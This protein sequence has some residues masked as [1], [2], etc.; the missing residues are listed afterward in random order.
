MSVNCCVLAGWAAAAACDGRVS[1]RRFLLALASGFLLGY[2]STIKQTSGLVTL[3]LI[4]GTS[5]LL[6]WGRRDKKG[7]ALVSGGIALGALAL[8]GCVALWLAT[9]GLLG[10]FIEQTFTVGPSSKGGLLRSLVR[11]LYLTSRL[12][13]LSSAAIKAIAL[14]ALG[15]VGYFSS[16]KRNPEPV[17]RWYWL[18]TIL[19]V[20]AMVIGSCINRIPPPDSR[21]PTLVL[22]YVSLVG[23]LLAFA[24]WVGNL[25]VLRRAVDTN[26]ALLAALGFGCAY[27]L[28]MSWPAFEIMILPG[29]SY[30]L[31]ATLQHVAGRL[32]GVC[33]RVSAIAGCLLIVITVTWRKHVIPQ[34]W[35]RWSE[36][37]I[38]SSTVEPRLPELAGF[39]LSPTTAEFFENVTATIVAHSRPTDAIFVYPNMPIF[40][41]LARRR[42]ATRGLSHWVDTCPDFLAEA[43]A[44][45]LLA[46]PPMVIV[47]RP[48]LPRELSIEEALFRGGRPSNPRAPHDHSDAAAA[49]SARSD[50]SGLGSPGPRHDLFA[51]ERRLLRVAARAFN[52]REAKGK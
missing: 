21:E 15:V 7:I 48:D 9:S 29:L 37:P 40:Y 38:A 6:L 42:P 44:Q 41:G 36:P 3:L 4:Q 2:A 31:A 11:P 39:R 19:V 22:C 46:Q 1:G 14:I 26:H 28:S 8:L 24:T 27:A 30:L 23:C 43:D 32:L 49:I 20:V 47:I 25:L 35:G 16:R 33:Y 17:Q 12:D 13:T 45:R 52:S 5:L 50:V 51:E 10:T 18:A 34:G